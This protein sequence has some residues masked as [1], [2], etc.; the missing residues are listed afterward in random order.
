MYSSSNKQKDICCPVGTACFAS[1]FSPSG[2]YCAAVADPKGCPV[3]QDSPPVCVASTDQCAAAVGGGCC[4]NGSMCA[5]NGCV[6]VVVLPRGERRDVELDVDVDADTDTD[7][8]ADVTA[9]AT[10]TVTATATTTVS[11]VDA[12][13]NI[14]IDVA[15]PVR[16]RG[17]EV[18]Q[19]VTGLKIAEVAQETCGAAAPRLVPAVLVVWRGGGGGGGGGDSWVEVLLVLGRLFV[20][21]VIGGL[22]V[23][24]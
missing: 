3:S 12:N 11:D 8:D 20:P 6:R 17:V 4:P 2:I 9:T 5:P 7:T 18:T 23:M 21:L 1:T 10:V 19:T 13:V 24:F 14:N 22:L 16:P 15:T